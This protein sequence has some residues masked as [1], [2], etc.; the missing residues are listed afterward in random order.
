MVETAKILPLEVPRTANVAALEGELSAL[1]RSA[2]EDPAIRQ[3]VTRA[4][5]LTLL[6]YVESEEAG[7]EVSGLIGEATRQTPFRAVIMISEP[8]A[9]PAGLMAW[10][11]AHCH[12]PTAGEK[13]VC[14][15]EVTRTEI[16]A[17]SLCP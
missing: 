10:V 7:R 9:A 12:L 17:M 16:W 13:Q 8:Q 14:C 1:W 5:A 2:A 6:A 15:E 4:C 3:A 11:S